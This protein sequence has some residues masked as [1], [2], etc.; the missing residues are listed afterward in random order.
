MAAP[1]IVNVISIYGNTALVALANSALTTANIIQNSTGTNS[2]YKLD[3]VIVSN[4]SANTV[5]CNV[6]L[7]RNGV[8]YYLVGNASVPGNSS[9]IALGKD[10]VLY[11]IEGDTLQA[12]TSSNG[13]A[14]IISSYEVIS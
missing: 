11:M 1:N 4:N 5:T 12:N 10:T 14:S 7:N 6:A 8:N 3:V 13:V 9:L 2:V